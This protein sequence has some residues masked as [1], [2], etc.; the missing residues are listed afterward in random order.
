MASELGG[1]IIGGGLV[2]ASSLFSASFNECKIDFASKEEAI[3]IYNS[4]YEKTLLGDKSDDV[5]VLAPCFS[6]GYSS[7]RYL[8]TSL[9][10]QVISKPGDQFVTVDFTRL[11]RAYPSFDSERKLSAALF[12]AGLVL[13]PGEAHGIEE[14]GFFRMSNSVFPEETIERIRQKLLT[15]IKDFKCVDPYAPKNNSAET[16]NKRPVSAM[17]AEPTSSSSSSSSAA[18]PLSSEPETPSRP[19]KTPSKTAE[20][21]RRVAAADN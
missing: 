2:L 1:L 21:R 8:F 10:F 14:P 13:S 11:I 5:I 20:K 18:A 12:A 9:G 19:T 6:D 3:K 4:Q 7:V 15:V 16:S 17:A